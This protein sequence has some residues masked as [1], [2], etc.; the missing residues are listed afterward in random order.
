MMK[1][2]CTALLLC[3]LLLCGCTGDLEDAA[4][5]AVNQSL[6]VSTPQVQE[7]ELAVAPVPS[8]EAVTAAPV[9]TPDPTPTP[10]PTPEPPLAWFEEE[11]MIPLPQDYQDIKYDVDYN[12][13]G[14]IFTSGEALTSVTVTI[15]HVDRA[16]ALYPYV[17]TVTF[18]PAAGVTEY[19][20]TDRT[21]NVE[22]FSLCRTI[23]TGKLKEGRHTLVMTVTTEHHSEP[24][25][26]AQGS[27]TL[28]K[29]T[30]FWLT[31]DMFSNYAKVYQFFGGDTSRFLFSFKWQEGEQILI[32]QSW[33]EDNIVDSPVG[34]VHKDAAPYFEQAKA[35]IDTTYVRVQGSK[36]DSGVILLSKLVMEWGGAYMPRFQKDKRFVSM[37]ALGTCVDLNDEMAPNKNTSDNKALIADEVKNCLT[38]NGIETGENG[39]EYYDFSYTGSYRQYYQKVPKS[40]IN[41]LLYE[42]AFYRAG[43]GWGYYFGN[44]S[45]GMHYSLTEASTEYFTDP[46]VGLRKVFQY[47]GEEADATPD[48][49]SSA[50]PSASVS[51]GVGSQG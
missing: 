21:K 4:P 28:A 36:S 48:P 33:R 45:D 43:F 32:S 38:Y 13:Q 8:S 47:I 34:R 42:L 25:T 51:D 41:Y 10:S 9:L 49:L 30:G 19:D 22:D 17:S 40:V 15:Q 3:C 27:F 46:E 50:S 6:A 1:Y 11:E 18:D 35:F 2:C 7:I 5:A 24:F 23:E 26:V 37:H 12:F 16:S 31:S 39:V 29:K 20:L 14:K 44:S